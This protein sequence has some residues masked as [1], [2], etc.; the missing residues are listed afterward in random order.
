M[1]NLENLSSVMRTP[2]FGTA[3][4]LSPLGYILTLLEYGPNPIEC[5][6]EGS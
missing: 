6:G 1:V 4:R 3:G 2:L 5:D